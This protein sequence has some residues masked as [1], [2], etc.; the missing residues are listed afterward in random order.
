VG[1]GYGDGLRSVLGAA[2]PV[3]GGDGSHMGDGKTIEEAS[4]AHLEVP[5][6]DGAIIHANKDK[7]GV[8]IAGRKNDTANRRG[9]VDAHDGGLG[10]AEV[11][12][13]TCVSRGTGEERRTDPD[14][15]VGVRRPGD[16]VVVDDGG[17]G[18][19]MDGAEMLFGLALWKGLRRRRGGRRG[20]APYLAWPGLE[21]S[22]MMSSPLRA[23]VRILL[24]KAAQSMR[25]TV[26]GGEEEVTSAGPGD[27]GAGAVDLESAALPQVFGRLYLAR[28]VG[29]A[30]DA[31]GWGCAS[32]ETGGDARPRTFSAS[33]GDSA[34][35]AAGHI[36]VAGERDLGQARVAGRPRG[37]MR[38]RVRVE[39]HARA[40]ESK[41]VDP[42]RLLTDM[43]GKH[44]NHF[45]IDVIPVQPAM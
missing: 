8:P 12:E 7:E 20:D 25:R 42:C 14:A 23:L 1:G 5:A 21:R 34:V 35:L 31:E 32:A 27:V 18:D 43:E 41:Y 10:F 2:V 26:S 16:A 37:W 9:V 3:E 28:G 40:R 39:R 36:A 15:K 30:E 19:G 44:D 38:P 4:L 6:V 24:L 33:D 17:D 29:D 22:Q 13:E 11:L 45:T